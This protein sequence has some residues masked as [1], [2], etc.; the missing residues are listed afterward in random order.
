MTWDIVFIEKPKPQVLGEPSRALGEDVMLDD[1][2]TDAKVFVFFFPGDM[3]TG[4]DDLQ[5]RL[6]ALGRRT[7]S[8][9]FV[10]IGSLADKDYPAAAE[11]F[12]L[13]ALPA[14][15]VT[16]TSPL[17]ASPEGDT[18]FVRLDAQSL[19]AKPEL[20]TRTVEQLFNLF[21]TNKVSQAVRL[22]TWHTGRAALAAVAER[23]WRSVV[24]PVVTWLAEREFTLN[25]F[26]GTL[27]VKPSGDN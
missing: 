16:A 27:E 8:N 6:R 7:G 13:V 1:L 2:P 25:F 4:T 12:G 23:V 17:A 24:Q 26:E 5:D 10:D 18:A 15:V 14:I 20:L 19:F 11:R 3:S 21:L 9:L 22:G